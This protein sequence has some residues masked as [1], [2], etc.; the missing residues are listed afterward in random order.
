M[1]SR[2]DSSG[3]SG[4]IE[5]PR[6]GTI[7]ILMWESMVVSSGCHIR[8]GLVLSCVLPDNTK[9]ALCCILY[10]MGRQFGRMG[11]G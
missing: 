1:L 10:I 4:V 3:G 5:V 11:V 7:D 9:G 2:L 6:L 8:S